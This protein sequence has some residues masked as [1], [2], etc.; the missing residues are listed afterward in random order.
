MTGT[1]DSDALRD[2]CSAM[3]LAASVCRWRTWTMPLD[4]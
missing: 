1:N 2:H 3:R 4:A